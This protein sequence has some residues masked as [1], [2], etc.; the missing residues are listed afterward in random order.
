MHSALGWSDN[1]THLEPDV[2]LSL[3]DL[4]CHCTLLLGP[5]DLGDHEL[6]A[7]PKLHFLFLRVKVEGDHS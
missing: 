4:Q 3:K 1:P 5:L 6:D 7:V 2:S